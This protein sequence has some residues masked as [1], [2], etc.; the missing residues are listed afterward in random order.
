[1]GGHLQNWTVRA[2]RDAIAADAH[3]PIT[4]LDDPDPQVRET[5]A[6]ALAAASA[7]AEEI[8][9]ALHGRLRTETAPRVR[10]SLVLVIA[11]LAREHRHEG[12]AVF[13]RA[14]WSEATGPSEVRVCAALGWLCLVED[15]VPDTLRT[16]IEETVTPELHRV[17]SPTPW[18][19]QVDDLGVAG[20]SHT[21]WQM[22]DPETWPGPAPEPCF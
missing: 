20:L 6:Y 8:S 10:A 1:M 16:M 14:L 12:A 3:I 9:A 18:L 19:T 4:L 21:L 17:L 5:A 15:P 22:L 11:Q 7:R 2:V 13:T